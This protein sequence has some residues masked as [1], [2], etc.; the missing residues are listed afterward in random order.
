MNV[1]DWTT[2]ELSQRIDLGPDGLIPLEV[3]FLHDPTES[4]AYVGCALGSSVFRIYKN[5]VR[6]TTISPINDI[7]L[8]IM[9]ETH[10]QASLIFFCHNNG[11][12]STPI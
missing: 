4:E 10:Y 9:P 6:L 11:G 8:I 1:W 12:N 2:H 7:M 3:R 5:D